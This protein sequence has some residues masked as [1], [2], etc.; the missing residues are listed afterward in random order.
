MCNADMKINTYYWEGP[1][2][3]K[4]DWFGPRKCTDWNMVQAWAD[5][6][7]INF[8]GNDDALAKLILSNELGSFGLANLLE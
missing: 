1:N 5:E 4:G 6:R 3:P 2:E 7:A 8:K